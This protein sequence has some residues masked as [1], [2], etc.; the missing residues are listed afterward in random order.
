MLQDEPMVSYVNDWS[1]L[2]VGE[3]VQVWKTPIG[4]KDTDAYAD[5]ACGEYGIGTYALTDVGEG[6][7]WIKAAGVSGRGELVTQHH[8]VE[9]SKLLRRR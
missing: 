2:R 3:Q 7:A 9:L 1:T 5:K 8:D 4:W 6:Y